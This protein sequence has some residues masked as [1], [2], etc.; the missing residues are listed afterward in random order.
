MIKVLVVDDSAVV[1]QILQGSL[2]ADPD[3]QVVGTAPDPYVARDMIV[4]LKPDV[5]TLDVEMPR[6]DGI[7]FLRKLMYYYP[8]PGDH[9]VVAD[10]GRR[11]TGPGGP[12][13]RRGRGNAQA[14]RG[15]QR[16]RHGGRTDRQDQDGSLRSGRQARAAR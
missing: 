9:R 16:G 4:E 13:G 3:I 2:A 11:R 1:R 12:G 14:G 6:M 15:V 8:L 10:L 5:V 7:T